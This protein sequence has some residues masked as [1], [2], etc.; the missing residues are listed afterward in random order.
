M[1][2]SK[3]N[4]TA[5]LLVNLFLAVSTLIIAIIGL[6]RGAGE[7]QVGE[8]MYGLG[9]LKAFTILSNI[10]C[11][12]A[13]FVILVFAVNNAFEKKYELPRW[14]VVFQFTAACAVGLTFITVVVFLAPMQ[15]VKGNSY[16]RFFRDD[17]FFF[18]FLNPVLAGISF[19]LLEKKYKIGRREQLLAL[20]PTFIYSW[21]YF[22]MVVVVKGWK[23]FY[24]FTFNN[25]YYMIPVSFIAMYG[26][27]WLISLF[28]KKRHN[29]RV[30]ENN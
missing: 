12:I 30:T 7:G 15:V 3:K 22:V 6:T 18:H 4:N 23:D 16:F 20:I 29:R 10:Y 8:N 21:L 28:Y 1:D 11:G 9:Y 26:F 5:L 27:T 2:I 17:M 24:G 19:V 13:S 25:R 14:A